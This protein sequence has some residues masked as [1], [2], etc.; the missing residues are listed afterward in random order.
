MEQRSAS[1]GSVAFRPPF[2]LGWSR[3]WLL[4]ALCVTGFLTCGTD[5]QAAYPGAN[6]RIVF[7]SMLGGTDPEI[8]TI[9]PDG[10][11]Q[12]QLTTNSGADPVWS[13]DGRHIAFES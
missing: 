2:G 12:V 1:R 3:N 7:F 5:A 6:G 4:A 13:P 11:D 8:F 10:G 9:R